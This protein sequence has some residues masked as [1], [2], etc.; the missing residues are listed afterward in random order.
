MREYVRLP[1][2]LLTNARKRNS[3]IKRSLDY[4]QAIKK[5]EIKPRGIKKRLRTETDRLNPP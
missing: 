1:E 2:E 4:A 5:K 3:W